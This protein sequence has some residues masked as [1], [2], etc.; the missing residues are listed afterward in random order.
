[1]L[2]ISIS[3]TLTTGWT[4]D[5]LAQ[6]NSKYHQR[7]DCRAFISALS[8]SSKKLRLTLGLAR[9]HF[10]LPDKRDFLMG[11]YEWDIKNNFVRTSSK[12]IGKRGGDRPAG[13]DSKSSHTTAYFVTI[14]GKGARR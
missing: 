2:L 1:M 13:T 14:S 10:Y 3:Y 12:T 5:K 8:G 6:Q 7:K 4:L 9:H 11:A